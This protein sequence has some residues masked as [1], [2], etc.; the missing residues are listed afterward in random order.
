[1][2]HGSG[3]TDLLIVNGRQISCIQFF[4]TSSLAS[5][6]CLSVLP[7]RQ[8]SHTLL[9][10]R[11]TLDRTDCIACQNKPLNDSKSIIV[12]S[13]CLDSVRV[14]LFI[15]FLTSCSSL[16]CLST[17][18]LLYFFDLVYHAFKSMLDYVYNNTQHY[19]R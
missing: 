7:L 9:A 6:S 16:C 17:S 11:I 3:S 5:A 15:L 8:T 2:K 19:Y 12:W 18:C 4:R 10:K 14:K 13:M 1:M